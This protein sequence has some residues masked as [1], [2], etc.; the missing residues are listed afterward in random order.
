MSIRSR[1]IQAVLASLMVAAA[2]PSYALEFPQ[3]RDRGAPA[4]GPSLA[5]R[6]E[7]CLDPQQKPSLTS[8]LPHNAISTAFGADA[9][10]PLSLW[11]YI[12]ETGAVN[13]ELTVVDEVG[14]DVYQ[15]IV[16][17]PDT[18]GTIQ[19]QLPRYQSDGVTPIF[20]AGNLYYWDLA[21][22]CDPRDRSDDVLIGGGIQRLDASPALLAELEAAADD[23]LAQAELYA[24]AGAWQETLTLAASLRST[25]PD[26]WT[27]LLSSVDLDAVAA[28]PIV[29]QEAAVVDVAPP[30]VP[31]AVPS[32]D[33]DHGTSNLEQL[34]DGIR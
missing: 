3:T 28:Q 14:E 10:I 16:T 23:A 9:D 6:G 21:L 7:T 17:L 19:L 13:A 22:V 4:R 12:P 27:Q 8:I 15:E 1:F 25:N 18:P 24:A 29:G 2:G 31:M 33:V 11:F 5:T 26:P 34:L 20:A 32:S 30:A